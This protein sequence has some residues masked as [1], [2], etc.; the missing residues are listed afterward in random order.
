MLSLAQAGVLIL[1]SSLAA[2]RLY[3]SSWEMPWVWGWALVA[4]ERNGTRRQ[5]QP[6]PVWGARVAVGVRTYRVHL[7]CT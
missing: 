6:Q 1:M 3:T 7:P 4:A 2:L 5:E